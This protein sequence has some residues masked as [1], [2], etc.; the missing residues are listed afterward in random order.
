MLYLYVFEVVMS[1]CRAWT[2]RYYL[3]SWC[4]I[5]FSQSDVTLLSRV[6]DGSISHS[7]YGQHPCFM[8]SHLTT[9]C[10]CSH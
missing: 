8:A 1:M 2:L 5:S 7:S 4:H 6:F 3:E 10:K 9:Q